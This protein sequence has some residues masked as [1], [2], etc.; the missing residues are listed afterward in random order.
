MYASRSA[1][2]GEKELSDSLFRKFTELLQAFSGITIREY[3][4]YLMEYRLQKLVGPGK[5][6]SNFQDLYK[7]LVSNSEHARVE[8]V[9]VLTTNYTY[10]YREEVHFRFLSH[11]LRTKAQT[12]PYLRFWSAACASGEEAYSMAITVAEEGTAKQIQ[13]VRILAT[14][15]SLK[16]LEFALEGVYPYHRIRGHIPDTYLRKYFSFDPRHNTFTVKEQLKSLVTFRY[17]NLMDPYPFQKQF[18]VVFLRNVL[19]Y[20]DIHEK[21][22]IL[23]KIFSVIKPGGF[24]VLGL[25]E[26]L[27]GVQHSFKPLKHSIYRRD[28]PNT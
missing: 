16:V 9:N 12:Q 10:F 3:K 26:S 27:V 11:Y 1:F 5:R 7:A 21:E 17:L 13:D 25:S 20:F 8:F 4:K 18:D 28:I 23:T 15:I 19:I 6:F 2:V 24:L 14:D 22:Q